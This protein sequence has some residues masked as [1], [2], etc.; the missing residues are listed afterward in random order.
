MAD[1]VWQQCRYISTAVLKAL[2]ILPQISSV[3]YF[4]DVSNGKACVLIL[5]V[6]TKSNIC[7]KLYSSSKKDNESCSQFGLM[8]FRESDENPTHMKPKMFNKRD[9]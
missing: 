2:L 6:V 8:L 7:L 5:N 9:L 1:E 4:G 3:V